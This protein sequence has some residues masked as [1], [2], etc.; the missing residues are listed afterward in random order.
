MVADPLHQLAPL[1]LKGFS[2]LGPADI[3][4]AQIGD[5][6]DDQLRPAVGIVQ[7]DKLIRRFLGHTA[8]HVNVE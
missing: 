8:D 4:V 1:V 2:R 7:H 3:A 6:A 5:S